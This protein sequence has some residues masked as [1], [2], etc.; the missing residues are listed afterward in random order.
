MWTRRRPRTR[1]MPLILSVLVAWTFVVGAR[2]D[3]TDDFVRAEMKRQNIPALSLAVMR[4]GTIVKAEG[5]GV[6]N[7]Q[8]GTPATAQTVY[9]IGS[10]SKQFIATGVMLLVQDR[11]IAL[12]DAIGK[13]I[14]DAPASWSAITVRHLLTHTAGVVRESPGFQPFTRQSDAEVLSS[15]YPVPLRF[16]PGQKWEYSNL[17]YYALAE[18]ITRVAGQPWSG[19]LAERIFKPAGMSATRPTTLDAVPNRAVGYTDNDN[20]MPAADWAAVRPSG[21]FLS[22]VLDLARWDAVLNTNAVLTEDARRQM[23]T[24]VSL[25]DGTSYPYGFG[26]Y[27]SGPGQRR[28]VYHG[29]GLPGFV[30]QFRRYLDDRVTVILLMNSDDVDD[31]TI[32]FGVAERHLPERR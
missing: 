12:D 28:E 27:L 20:L 6:A 18:M 25:N 5:Y 8:T 17:G 24:A 14:R 10:V 32:A 16:V 9:K 23:W 1:R 3:A 2:A 19:F 15:A 13:Y 22:T 7:L 4:D 30:A 29:G 31:E 21:A 26:W 11:R